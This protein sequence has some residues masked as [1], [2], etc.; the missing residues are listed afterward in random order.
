MSQLSFTHKKRRYFPDQPAL[1][2]CLKKLS[3]LGLTETFWNEFNFCY[4]LLLKRLGVI[5]ADIN[6]VADYKETVCLKNIRTLLLRH[7]GTKGRA[8]DIGIFRD[9]RWVAPSRLCFQDRQAPRQ[10]HLLDG[11]PSITSE[12]L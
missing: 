6:H 8:R 1:S 3:T 9:I 12:W 7:Q 4:L 2:R 11:H 5:K 10:A